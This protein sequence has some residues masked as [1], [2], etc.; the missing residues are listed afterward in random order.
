MARRLV[1]L[2]DRS[3]VERAV[4]DCVVTVL[5]DAIRVR[6]RADW[7]VTGGTVGI[8]SLVAVSNHPN[9]AA[10][11]WNRVHV[12]WGDERFVPEGHPD[13]NDAQARGALFDQIA[14]P[15]ENL[16]SFPARTNGSVD[17]AADQFVAEYPGGFPVFDLVLNGIGPDGHVA[18][19]FPGKDHG[20]DSALVLAVHDSPK[21]PA[22]RLTFTFAA[23]NNSR[24]VWI[25]AAGADKA[26]AVVRLM[27][28]DSA[29]PA[30]KLRGE[31]ETVVCV[32][33]A[34]A[35]NLTD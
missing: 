22:E 17:M 10:V 4:A 31:T 7:V 12:W 9:V 8:G 11:D 29:T 15:S 35:T 25:V 5:T 13:R 28:N 18:S 34:A 21:P 27:S 3:S 16:H 19:L 26:G 33:T 2:P 30:T 24:H 32:D 20:S 14:I 1:I 6:G 23:L